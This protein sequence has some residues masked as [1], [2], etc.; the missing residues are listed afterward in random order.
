MPVAS[1]VASSGSVVGAASRI[2]EPV[3]DVRPYGVSFRDRRV[4][5]VAGRIELE[6]QPFH[7][8][9]RTQIGG[10]GEREDLRELRFVE[11]EPSSSW[12][13]SMRT[14]GQRTRL[15]NVII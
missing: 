5:K 14:T 7:Y 1:L 12:A 10:R 9:P 3:Q 4:V 8:R 2:G 13:H 6:S 15:L 11:A